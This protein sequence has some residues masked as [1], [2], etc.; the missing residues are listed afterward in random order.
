M[1][2]F[3]FL[4]TLTLFFMTGCK[5]KDYSL[6]HFELGE[7][8]IFTLCDNLH[9]G[10][11]Q[12][13][14]TASDELVK[15]CLPNG[16]SSEINA[17]LVQNKKHNIL[18]DSGL[19]NN[20]LQNLDS[21]NV[22]SEQIDIILITHCH[23]DHIGGLVKD[24]QKVF[25]NATI[26]LSQVEFDYW[27]KQNNQ[28][29]DEV[30]KLY[31]N[32]IKTFNPNNINNIKEELIEN[33]FPIATYGHTPGHTSFLLKEREEQILIW[34]DITH[35]TDVQFQNPEIAVTYDVDP[36]QAVQTRKEIF[37]F[38]QKNDIVIAGMHI[39]SPAIGK[40]VLDENNKYNYINFE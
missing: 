30:A 13:L 3:A 34:G 32:N 31:E 35:V 14:I 27:S 17:F 25:N 15:K 36:V 26:Y 33:I 37:D 11:S 18:I 22:K 29:F 9:E 20:L 12:I 24:G 21:L 10:N 39:L 23:G 5:S 2:K 38:V 8:K 6:P 7:Y 40:I 28:L 4:L 19:G 1:K 16:F